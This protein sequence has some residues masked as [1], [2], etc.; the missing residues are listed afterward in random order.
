VIVPRCVV[1]LAVASVLVGARG[2]RAADV[3]CV[4]EPWAAITVSS[5]IEGVVAEVLVD[6][7]ALVK[8]GQVVAKLDSTVEE[9]AVAV[10]R[11]R[12][13][14]NGQVMSSAARLEFADKKLGRQQRLSEQN[15]VSASDKDESE[16]SKRVAEAE[17]QEAKESKQIA[18]FEL[19]HA[20][21]VLDQR[22]I[23][24]PVDGVVVQRILAAGEYTN[25][26]QIMKLAQIDPLRVEVFAPL[27]LFGRIT[28]GM[29]GEVLPEAPVGGSYTAEVTVVDKVIDAASGTFG[30]RLELPNP[31]YALPAGL[32]CRVKF[33]VDMDVGAE[34]GPIDPAIRPALDKAH[35]AK[36]SIADTAEVPI[37][38]GK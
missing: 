1:I 25:P 12:A 2:A 23:R 17:V 29:K 36:P 20:E 6:R 15:V 32:K 26:P 7:G 21:A 5:A 27:G 16:S 13:R 30:V 4:I 34:R 14:S 37:R 19:Q 31:T 11:A 35:P 33:P 24:S 3:D 9:A 10:A 28:P 22:T 8:R 18:E 38:A